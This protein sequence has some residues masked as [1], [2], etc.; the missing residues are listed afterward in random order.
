M[1]RCIDVSMSR[2][3][4]TSSSRFLKIIYTIK[5]NEFSMFKSFDPYNVL[6]IR[7]T[8]TL[9]EIKTRFKKLT[10][11]HH[12]DR[13]RRKRN[14]NPKIYS[15]IC[16]AY[17]IL[18]D[19]NNRREFDHQFAS[20]FMDLRETT[21]DFI[22]DQNKQNVL[23]VD[24]DSKQSRFSSR[25]KFGDGDLAAFNSFFD[26][27][28]APTPND[29]G[30]GGEM[31]ERMSE[32]EAKS[33]SS[34]VQDLRQK[35]LFK[36]TSFNSQ[37]FNKLFEENT[38]KDA[39]R[40]IIERSDVDPSAFSLAEQTQ[41][42]DIAVHNGNM[43]VGRD[44]KDYSKHGGDLGWVDYQR[45]FTT[46][47]EGLPN[48]LKQSFRDDGN[49]DRMF[50]QR[51]SEH[52]HNPYDDIPEHDRKSF[53]QSKQAIISQKARE[54]EREQRLHKDIVFKYKNQYKDNYIGHKQKANQHKVQEPTQ[55]QHQ[56]H[57]P[58][59]QQ[60]Q[61]QSNRIQKY[62]QHQHQN[63]HSDGGFNQQT[64]DKDVDSKNINDRMNQRNFMI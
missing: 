15:D 58:Y 57:Q 53:A 36:D 62:R 52:S 25:D 8:A 26:S 38:C 29:H 18:I 35:N 1:S 11:K 12:P 48:D 37:D 50:Q 49:I 64:R 44:T 41:F 33:W 56:R 27:N 42:T 9:D 17:A 5:H 40:E 4:D 59:R 19:P 47:S 63:S 23:D 54:L 30:Y 16:K 3:L 39:S 10:L 2:C 61:Q 7:R 51:M 43:I 22:A 14:Y 24:V 13:N 31:S 46:I 32:K 60:P 21:K 55:K 34:S 45:G 20:S 28:R 6:D